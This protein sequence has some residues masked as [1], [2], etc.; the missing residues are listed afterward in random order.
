MV[1]LGLPFGYSYWEKLGDVPLDSYS[2]ACSGAA[3]RPGL[4]YSLACEMRG[5]ECHSSLI[6]THENNN[7]KIQLILE[8]EKVK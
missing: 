5:E 6:I 3:G 2:T 7:N 4:W 1:Q 8:M